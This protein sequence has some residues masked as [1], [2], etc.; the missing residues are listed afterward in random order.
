MST[1]PVSHPQHAMLTALA[2]AQAGMGDHDTAAALVT[3]IREAFGDDGVLESMT[4]WADAA[5]LFAWPDTPK[6]EPVGLT[7]RDG[8]TNQDVSVDDA[9]YGQRWAGRWIAARKAMDVDT[10]RALLDAAGADR[11][12]EECVAGVL[13]LAA[14]TVDVALDDMIGGTE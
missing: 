11:R 7:F 2:M 13:Y 9:T 8:T 5:G 6:G 14:R 10:A 3:Q 1:L 12:T 4:M